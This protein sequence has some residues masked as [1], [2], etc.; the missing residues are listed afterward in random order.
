MKE[1]YIIRHA[2][3]ISNA[4]QK[5]DNHDQIPL[6]EKGKGQAKELAEKLDIVPELIV[7]SSYSRTRETAEPFIAKHPNVPIEIWD[8]HEFTYLAKHHYNGKTATERTDA[9][10]D[11]WKNAHIHHKNEDSESFHELTERMRA[12]VA[13]LKERKE[14]IITIFSHGRFIYALQLYLEKL[15]QLGKTELTDEEI[16][17]LKMANAQTFNPDVKFPIDNV[18]V[19]KIELD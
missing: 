19:H 4:G 14:N 5:A 16:M 6:S 7:V 10:Y 1:I 11:Y 15:K 12:F 17:E 8:V 13:K 9:A 18:S 2:E 3:S